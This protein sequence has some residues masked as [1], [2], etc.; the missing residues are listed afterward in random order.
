MMV[1]KEK[2]KEA[3]AGGAKNIILR[4]IIFHHELTHIGWE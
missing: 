3:L 2:N 1:A 4:F